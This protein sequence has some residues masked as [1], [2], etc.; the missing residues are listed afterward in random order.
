MPHKQKHNNKVVKLETGKL[1][2]QPVA[3]VQHLIRI[4][5]SLMRVAEKETQSLL[6]GD[7]MAFAILQYEKEKLAGDYVR[8][9]EEFRS[10]LEE[11][12]NVDKRLLDQLEKQQKDLAEKSRDNNEL[13]HQIQRRMKIA[14]EGAI[15]HPRMGRV[16]FSETASQ[17]T[18][19]A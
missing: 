4:T 10:R 1:P 11:F 13:A 18:E 7:T 19:G 5:T 2:A 3:A 16:R 9:S 12:R 17:Q 14:K 6:L 8:S 15:A